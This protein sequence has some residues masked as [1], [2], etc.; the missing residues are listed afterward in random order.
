MDKAVAQLNIEHYR[1]LLSTVTDPAKR[2]TLR[3]LLV[4]DRGEAGGA[5]EQCRAQGSDAIEL[6]QNSGSGTFLTFPSGGRTIS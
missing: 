6:D 1:K 4:E 5:A 3:R 2:A